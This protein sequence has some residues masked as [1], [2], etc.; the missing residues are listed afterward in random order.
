MP[1]CL[2]ATDLHGRTGRYE[3]LL[4]AI[5]TERPEAVFLGGDASNVQ[6]ERDMLVGPAVKTSAIECGVVRRGV[7]QEDSLT[8]GIIADKRF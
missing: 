4:T 8:E 6:I 7:E 1:S 3:K 5:T 2:F